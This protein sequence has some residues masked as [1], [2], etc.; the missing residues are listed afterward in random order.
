MLNIWNNFQVLTPL[1]AKKPL[2][3]LLVQITVCMCSNRDHFSRTVLQ[4]Y[5][6]DINCSLDCGLWIKRIPSFRNPNQNRAELWRIFSSNKSAP[7]NRKKGFYANQQAGGWIQFCMKQLR[8]LKSFKIFKSEMK[9]PIAVDL[10][11]KAYPMIP[12]SCRSNLA[13]RYL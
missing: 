13:R 7:A 10:P 6:R 1:H 8:T 9:K 2:I 3:L 5:G 11:L 4:K 12:L